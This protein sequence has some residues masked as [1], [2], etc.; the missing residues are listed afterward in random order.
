V[1]AA[2]T[3]VTVAASVAMAVV[4]SVAVASSLPT[5]ADFTVDLFTAN[6]AFSRTSHVSSRTYNVDKHAC[7][8]N[9]RLQVWHE[10]SNGAAARKKTKLR[11]RFW[12][13]HPSIVVC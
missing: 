12:N 2:V 7:S 3:V 4:L 11:V 8:H 9:V 10:I 13:R 6:G 1:V 5:A